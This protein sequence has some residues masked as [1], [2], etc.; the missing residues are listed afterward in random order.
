M[1]CG[2]LRD[3]REH[4]ARAAYGRRGAVDLIAEK[5]ARVGDGVPADREHV[6]I[7]SRH[8]LGGEALDGLGR[9][10]IEG[11]SHLGGARG[12]VAVA[13]SKR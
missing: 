10:R 3:L 9:S 1:W 7:V 11:H 5:V 8:V 6:P 12:G 4:A 13:V 2:E